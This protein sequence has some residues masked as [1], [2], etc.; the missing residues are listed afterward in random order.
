MKRKSHKHEIKSFA[1]FDERGNI[2]Y[3]TIRPNKQDAQTELEKFNTRL[4]GHYYPFKVLPVFIGIDSDFQ[5]DLED[6]LARKDN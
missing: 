2:L 1:A 4:E 6:F 3:A 5:Y